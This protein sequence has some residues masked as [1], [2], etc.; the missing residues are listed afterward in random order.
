MLYD[1]K[2]KD[3]CQ[4]MK[5]VVLV[6]C[7]NICLLGHAFAKITPISGYTNLT[8]EIVGDRSEAVKEVDREEFSLYISE[9]LKKAKKVK[10]EEINKNISVAES[11]AQKTMRKESEKNFFQKIYDK[12][13]RRINAPSNEQ[14]DD[15]AQE[16]EYIDA[17]SNINSQ[18]EV[19]TYVDEQTKKWHDLSIP[20]VT[21][22]LP[23]D[24]IAVSVPAV[25]HIPYLMNNIEILP[26]GMIKF[27]ETVV[28]VANGQKLKS[29]LT[30]ILP[31]KYFNLKGKAQSIDY[32]I[33]NVTINDEAINYHL[34][35]SDDRVLLVPDKEY[36]LPAGIYTYKFEYLADNVLL[37]NNDFYD[38]YWDVGG[39]GWNLVVDR[40]VAKLTAPDK[41]AIIKHGASVGSIRGVYK[42]SVNIQDDTLSYIY[43]A[44]VPLFMGN[45]MLLV[46]NI[47]KKALY[48]V[49]LLQKFVRSFYDYGDIYI[50]FLGLLIIAVSFAVSWR[51]ISEGKSRVKISLNKTS[52]MVR[53]ILNEKFDKKSVCGFLLD[54]YKKNIIDIQQSGE[55]ILIVKSTDSLKS[56]LSY[57]KKA[58]KSLFPA[59]ETT[60]SVAKNNKLPL[61]R[62][63]KILE[64]GL[65]KDILK[66][67]F[68]L[69]ISYLL[70][71]IAMM[72]VV[73]LGIS[74]FKINS[75]YVFN[76]LLLTTLPAFLGIGLWYVGNKKWQKYVARYFS[77]NIVF[78]CW[79]IYSAVIHPLA[80]LFLIWSVGF[81]VY[82]L[83]TYSKRNGLARSYVQDL[84][85]QKEQLLNQK[86]TIA[87]GKGFANYQALVF[88][89]DLE[90]EIKPLKEDE[91]YK[92]PIIKNIM[93]RL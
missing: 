49:G 32:S 50:S 63:I 42:N 59:H 16:D 71:N 77:I 21:A 66:F 44:N 36:R 35:K 68:K 56:L 75:L 65:K 37:D 24:N 61:K 40:T 53:H 2:F 31:S 6:L 17:L 41:N 79:V 74:S 60:F 64:K 57:E 72:L 19:I 25:E 85:K 11:E 34:A 29:G 33:I 18:E 88:V 27:E 87:L 86:D 55:T 52:L 8:R 12:A 83:K 90:E 84:L 62:F 58:I 70:F 1:Y 10:A 4:V 51:Y 7:F 22:V 30:K 28:V 91:Y 67:N 14:R 39:N 13:I 20:T 93:E 9:R 38:F 78:G 92:I 73:W 69:N 47:Y 82:S 81:V 26:N 48:P 3:E 5:K 45:S 15:V 80:A 54:L 23:P 46:A 43:S 89:C 76:V